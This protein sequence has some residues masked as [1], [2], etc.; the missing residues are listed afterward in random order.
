M[1]VFGGLRGPR[2]NGGGEDIRLPG[3]LGFLRCRA[4]APTKASARVSSDA[5]LALRRRR[6]YQVGGDQ[7]LL[8]ECLT[9]RPSTK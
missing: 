3:A 6:R 1:R 5:E 7:V 4:G 9:S 8:A 2:P